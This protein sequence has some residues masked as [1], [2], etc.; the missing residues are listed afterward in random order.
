MRGFAAAGVVAVH[1]TV[2]GV[3]AAE[4]GIAG[5]PVQGTIDR[6]GALGQVL[7]SG[8]AGVLLFFVLSG[9]LLS[10]PFV[11]SWVD[12]EPF[13]SI[14]RYLR[15][16]LLRIL[17]AYWIVL[18]VSLLAFG[19]LGASRRQ[20][21]ET[22]LLDVDWLTVPINAYLGQAWTL[23][24][25]MRFYLLLPLAGLLL[26]GVRRL[27]GRRLPRSARI[28][29]LVV[30]A[31]GLGLWSATGSDAPS[32]FR[33]T[34]A[35]AA[36]GFA[37]GVA[38][39]AIE[40]LPL[41]RLLAWRR[42]G[43]VALACGGAGLP[44][45]LYPPALAAVAR[46]VHVSPLVL[47]AL[48]GWLLVGSLLVAQWSGQR[49]PRAVDNPLTR[50]GGSRSYGIYLV[51]MPV[52]HWLLPGA[53]GDLDGAR[54]LVTA[55]VVTAVPTALLAELLHRCVELP[56]LRLKRRDRHT[57]ADDAPAPGRPRLLPAALRGGERSRAG[58]P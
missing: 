47:Q 35:T 56:F 31:L 3:Y 58:R 24:V 41:R 15:N 1:A 48:V 17:P 29:L 20:V 49:L 54:L 36:Y 25:E 37:P 28:W 32:A 53:V 16:R 43:V 45:W 40:Q 14:P 26:L 39:A 42:T 44:L 38:L 57:P 30:T 12:G 5:G 11:R 23:S 6:Y 22:Y 13:P 18:T 27:G 52:V 7:I 55:L 10:R 21:A 8:A 19:A 46:A 50:W 33:L 51:H 9:Y 34:F 4:P 2:F